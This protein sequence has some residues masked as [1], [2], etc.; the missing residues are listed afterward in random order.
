MYFKT[1]T[2]NSPKFCTKDYL[3]LKRKQNYLLNNQNNIIYSK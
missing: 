2:I 1:R 3:K